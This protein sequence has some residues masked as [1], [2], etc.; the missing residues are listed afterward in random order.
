M[1]TASVFERFGVVL[2][3]LAVGIQARFFH[4][5]A[6]L[7]VG[8]DALGAGHDFLPAHE[9]VV[10]IAERRVGWVGSG[11]EGTEGEGEFVE[12]EEVGVVF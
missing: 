12:G 1:G 11:V 8:M 7:G 3:A 4:S 9:E 6:K 5:G 10:G 2:E